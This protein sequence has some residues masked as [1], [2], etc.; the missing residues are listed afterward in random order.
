MLGRV[1]WMQQRDFF[2]K[3]FKLGTELEIAGGFIYDGLRIFGQMRAFTNEDVFSFLYNISVG[4]ER[5]EKILIVISNKNNN[6][7]ELLKQIRIHDHVELLSI[8]EENHCFE[9]A[10]K[11][12]FFLQLLSDFYKDMRYDNLEPKYGYY[13]LKGILVD[14]I[15]GIGIDAPKSLLGNDE[16]NSNIIKKRIGEIIGKIS[17]DLYKKIDQE[18]R[19]QNIYTTETHSETKSC[20]IFLEK[21]YTLFQREEFN[22]RNYNFFT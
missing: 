14:Y 22:K 11:H 17:S 13:G 12:M 2:W 5:L 21:N 4:I 7:S 15:Q 20:K 19:L 8:I 16:L 6:E 3:N 1:I 10:D 18:A 9:F